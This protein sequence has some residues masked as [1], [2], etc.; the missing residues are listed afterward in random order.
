MPNALPADSTAPTPPAQK[1]T[2]R[3][4]LAPMEGVVDAGVRQLISEIGG[5]DFCVT[6]F[7]RVTTELKPQKSFLKIC[8]ELTNESKTSNNTPVHFQLLGSAPEVLA[9]HAEKAA[10]YGANVVDLNFG[11]PAK[12]VNRHKGGAVLLQTPELIHEIVSACSEALRGTSARLTAKMRLGYEDTTRVFENLKAIEQGG[13]T[14]LV[15]HARTKVEGYKPPAH[16][17]W[18]AK[19]RE[20]SSIPIIANGEIWSL[21]DYHKCRDVSGCPDTMLGRGLLADPYLAR[22]IVDNC[23]QKPSEAD[24]SAA[25][26]IYLRRMQKDHPDKFLLSR[27]KQWLGM[28]QKGEVPMGKLFDAV[29]TCRDA[30]PMF[31][32]LEHSAAGSRHF[33]HYLPA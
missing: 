18:L 19:L 29:K 12:T 7:M 23:A 8:P 26:L 31:S 3:I 4:A 5:L 2:G 20:A 28:M 1:K 21:E 9:A 11:C 27:G 33:A 13:A 25:L 22:R 16:W 10:S 32:L 17:E 24:L 14:E 6:E 15:V 30:D